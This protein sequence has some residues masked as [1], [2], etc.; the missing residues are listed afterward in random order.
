MVQ[1]RRPRPLHSCGGEV[2]ESWAFPRIRNRD[3]VDQCPNKKLGSRLP[4][5]SFLTNR[6]EPLDNKDLV[7][8]IDLELVKAETDIFFI[9]PNYIK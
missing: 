1:S 7:K 2:E 5:S 4:E 9:I 3:L 8:D 6:G